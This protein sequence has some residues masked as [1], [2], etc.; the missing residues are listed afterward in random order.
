MKED[1]SHFNFTNAHIATRNNA[2]YVNVNERSATKNLVILR[3]KSDVEK[4]TPNVG[5]NIKE[6]KIIHPSM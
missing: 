1:I 6:K 4:Y 5:K 2:P 3:W